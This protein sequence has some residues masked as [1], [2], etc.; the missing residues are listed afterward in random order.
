MM[1]DLSNPVECAGFI[2][3]W[4]AHYGARNVEGFRKRMRRTADE[5][6]RNM[7]HAAHLG[8]NVEGYAESVAMLES[9][10]REIDP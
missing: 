3:E 7:R 2:K 6:R 9:A 8:C 5:Q 10:A 4:R 1:A